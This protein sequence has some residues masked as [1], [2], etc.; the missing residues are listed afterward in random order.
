MRGVKCP[1]S[2]VAG[3]RSRR[4]ERGDVP[5]APDR[6]RGCG[7]VS[8]LDDRSW[9]CADAAGRRWHRHHGV[10]AECHQ[11]TWRR[12]RL[13]TPFILQN[14]GSDPTN[15]TMDFFAFSDGSLVKTRTVSSLAPSNSVFHDP[16]S[17]PDLPAGGQFSVVIRSTNS[18]VVSVVNE[19][20]NVRNQ[21]RQEALSYQ[22]LSEGSTKTYA[23]YFAYNVNGWLT[24]LV[25]QNLGTVATTVSLQI[26]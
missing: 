6:L 1:A 13:A 12:R 10:S 3:L 17:D 11:E 18:P 22:G 8:V 21:Q 20:Q 5:F 7:F 2:G 9:S 14:V 15:V 25:V 19:H 24:T 16:N 4:E 23:P 26:A